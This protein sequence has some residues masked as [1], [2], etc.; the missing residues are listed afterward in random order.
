[1]VSSGTLAAKGGRGGATTTRHPIQG[2]TGTV[3]LARHTSAAGLNRGAKGE[4][5]RANHR[6]RRVFRSACVGTPRTHSAFSFAC[7]RKK[8][9]LLSE[10]GRERGLRTTTTTNRRNTILYEKNKVRTPHEQKTVI[11]LAC[12]PGRRE[13]KRAGVNSKYL[14]VQDATTSHKWWRCADR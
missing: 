5:G 1:M 11:F 10:T 9:V 6:E 4:R 8:Q 13:R 7:A 3:T 12:G 14:R 2:P